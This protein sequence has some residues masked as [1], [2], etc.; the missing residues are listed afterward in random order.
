MIVNAGSGASAEEASTEE[1]D[2][3]PNVFAVPGSPGGVSV[4]CLVRV[5]AAPRPCSFFL[6]VSPSACSDAGSGS[7]NLSAVTTVRSEQDREGRLPVRMGSIMTGFG[8]KP[9]EPSRPKDC[10]TGQ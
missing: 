5:A 6:D 4:P 1:K 2:S 7:A 10:G 9:L 3:Y 8:P